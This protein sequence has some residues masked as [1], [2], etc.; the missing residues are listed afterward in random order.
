M[1]MRQYK[2]QVPSDVDDWLK[3]EAKRNCRSKSAQIVFALRSIMAA[4]GK[5]GGEAPAAKGESAA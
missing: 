5:L 4:G 1:N 3:E 2:M